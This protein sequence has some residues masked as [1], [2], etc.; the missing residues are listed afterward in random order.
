M[1]SY[2]CTKCPGFCCSYPVIPIT[3]R[4]VAR[5]ARHFDLDFGTA[6]QRFTKEAHGRKYCLR[7]KTDEHFGRICKFFDT[8]ERRCTVY[9]ARPSTCR[10]YPAQKRCGYYDFLTFEREQQGDET[11]VARTDTANWR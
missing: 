6:K 10:D 4:D 1:A 9:H 7:R 2:D 8:E 3:K 11:W 5:L